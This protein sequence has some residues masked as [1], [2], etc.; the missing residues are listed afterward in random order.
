MESKRCVLAVAVTVSILMIAPVCQGQVLPIIAGFPTINQSPFDGPP[1]GGFYFSL[2]AR[3]YFSSFTSWEFPDVNNPQVDPLSR[4]EY[5]WEQIVGVAKASYAG[6]LL[7]LNVEGSSTLLVWSG[8][9]AQDS[10]WQN[11]DSPGQKTTFSESQTRPRI[12]TFDAS[13]AVTVPWVPRLKAVAG[14]R[15]QEFKFTNTDGLQ[16]TIAET[17]ENDNFIG[18]LPVAQFGSLPGAII[19]FSQYYKY[20]FLG[21]IFTTSF[22]LG[23]WPPASGPLAIHFRFQADIASVT[24]KNH[25]EHLLRP[26]VA[27]Y[28]YTR[29][30]AWHLNLITGLQV[31]RLARLDIEGDFKRIRTTGDMDDRLLGRTFSGAK[32]W[33][34]Q[35]YVGVNGSIKF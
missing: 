14:F 33:S 22:N 35:A 34:E 32:V 31:T 23:S 9:K 24:G 3:K 26:G 20:F 1:Q 11:P 17:D 18:Y 8:L 28:V 16:G 29:G 10:D 21:A 4:L 5:P 12:W 30:W 15:A 13:L 19:D 6:S 7:E 27:S 25:D 2:G